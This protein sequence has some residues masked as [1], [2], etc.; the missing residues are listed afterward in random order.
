MFFSIGIGTLGMTEILLLL[1]L[2]VLIFGAKRLPEIGA[3]LGQGIMNF[4]KSVKGEDAPQGS[5]GQV[6][7][8]LLNLPFGALNPSEAERSAG[9]RRRGS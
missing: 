7:E 2:A 8:R 3:G 6:G 5:D 9:R 1:G 4:K